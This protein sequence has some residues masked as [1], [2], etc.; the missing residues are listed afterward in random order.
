MNLDSLASELTSG[1]HGQGSHM[2]RLTLRLALRLLADH[3]RELQFDDGRYLSTIGDFADALR[4]LAER[5]RTPEPEPV[6]TFGNHQL[7]VRGRI[8]DPTCPDC[9]HEHEGREECGKYLG[10]GKF[11]HCPTKVP[12]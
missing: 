4:L 5:I 8:T 6:R 9:V 3:V 7:R 11:C 10:E 1:G 12:A 2:H